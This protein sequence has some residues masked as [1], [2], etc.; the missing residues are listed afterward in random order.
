MDLVSNLFLD[1]L[2]NPLTL[3]TAAVVTVLLISGLLAHIVE[4]CTDWG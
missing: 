4:L 3:L 2:L 1:T